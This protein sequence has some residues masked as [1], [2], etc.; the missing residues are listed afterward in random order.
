M[1]ATSPP[2]RSATGAPCCSVSP[3]PA[4]STITAPPAARSSRP[5]SSCCK[6]AW[7]CGHRTARRRGGSGAAGCRPA[8]YGRGYRSSMMPRP[9]P[10]MAD[11]VGASWMEAKALTCRL[12]IRAIAAST[13]TI[14][15][16]GTITDTFSWSPTTRAVVTE[17]T[18]TPTAK[19]NVR[20]TIGSSRNR[21]SRGDRLVKA[22]CTTRN[23]SEKMTVTSP[24]MPKPTATSVVGHPGAGHRGVKGDPGQQQAK[25]EPG[26]RAQQLHQAG[27]QPAPG[28]A[29]PPESAGGQRPHHRSR[30]RPGGAAAW[31]RLPLVTAYLPARGHLRRLVRCVCGVCPGR[32]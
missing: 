6:I 1:S 16:A 28:P 12:R 25:H 8:V 21:V 5:R 19:A 20:H 9:C 7:R 30:T 17:N 4:R 22:H 27:P 23:S 14:S 3:M 31:R 2:C 18:N 26:Q 15:A 10:A 24:R 32:T 13:A 11:S 29:E